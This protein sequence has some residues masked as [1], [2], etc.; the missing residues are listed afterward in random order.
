MDDLDFYN[1]PELRDLILHRE[2]RA[3]FYCLKA[4]DAGRYT[5]DHV[6]AQSGP[7]TDHSYRNVVACCFDCNSQKQATN[8]E[9]FLRRLYR[10]GLLDADEHARRV[11]VLR[12]L[13]AG[14]LVP[15]LI[16]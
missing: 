5:L 12:A 11:E 13:A 4:L 15:D 3:C 8:A 1:T 6:A 14:Q 10:K 16:G 9:D 7:T 2:N